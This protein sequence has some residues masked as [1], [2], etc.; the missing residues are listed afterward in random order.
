MESFRASNSDADSSTKYCFAACLLVFSHPQSHLPSC[1][2]VHRSVR[3]QMCLSITAQ[4]HARVNDMWQYGDSCL[5]IRY[6]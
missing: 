3:R 5:L 1:S 6:H 2:A 4:T